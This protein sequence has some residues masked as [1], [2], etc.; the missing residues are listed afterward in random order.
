MSGG[1]LSPGLNKPTNLIDI[2]SV[3][4]ARCINDRQEK[5]ALVGGFFCKPRFA[6]GVYCISLDTLAQAKSIRLYV[7]RQALKHP[8]QRMRF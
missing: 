6:A 1:V 5:T 8:F 2:P 4:E 7:P 3:E